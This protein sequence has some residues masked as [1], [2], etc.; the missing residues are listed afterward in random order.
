MLAPASARIVRSLPY[1]QITVEVEG[2]RP[3]GTGRVV[4]RQFAKGGP[5]DAVPDR[6]VETGVPVVWAM[7]AA[8]TSMVE[9]LAPA[10]A[11][12]SR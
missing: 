11:L 1:G 5:G 6:Y 12:Y 9:A 2:Q 7:A 10:S 8:A 3:G 4:L